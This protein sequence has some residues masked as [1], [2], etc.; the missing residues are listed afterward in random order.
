[1]KSI[2]LQKWSS[3]RLDPLTS[4]KQIP[5]N[6]PKPLTQRLALRKA[7]K[8]A[9]IARLASCRTSFT[10]WH[11]SAIQSI[12]R[13]RRQLG[14]GI[15]TDW[16][17]TMWKGSFINMYANLVHPD[18]S[19]DGN[20][21]VVHYTKMNKQIVQ[22]AFNM[23]LTIQQVTSNTTW[24][25]DRRSQPRAQALGEHIQIINS[26]VSIIDAAA[27]GYAVRHSFERQIGGRTP[28]PGFT[29]PLDPEITSLI[30][31]LG[32]MGVVVQHVAPAE[33]KQ[34]QHKV[35]HI[36]TTRLVL[37][38]LK[39]VLHIRGAPSSMT[40]SNNLQSLY[41]LAR[42]NNWILDSEADDTLEIPR[43]Q[44]AR[45]KNYRVAPRNRHLTRY[46]TGN[47]EQGRK[48]VTK[49]RKRLQLRLRVQRALCD[50]IQDSSTQTQDALLR[51][52]DTYISNESN[53]HLATSKRKRLK[54]TYERDYR[55]SRRRHCCRGT[56]TPT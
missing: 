28:Q 23:I 50:T 55:P 36:D 6:L 33:S 26:P 35:P 18:R 43:V 39:R 20:G 47:G 27:R 3:L 32:S 44:G 5:H 24:W 15:L 11:T 14:F 4:D 2:Q 51:T 37:T 21:P 17:T 19:H 16:A 12:L 1:M 52:R 7:D 46:S 34:S 25:S 30:N 40:S 54:K 48:F 56:H 8:T 49:R 13:T 10:E 41:N 22:K 29:L 42:D 45:F 9:R 38:E 31:E 53:R